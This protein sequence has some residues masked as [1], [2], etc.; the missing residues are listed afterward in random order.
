MP[1]ASDD[2]MVVGGKQTALDMDLSSLNVV[3]APEN[4]ITYQGDEIGVG[5][6][7]HTRL[8]EC[9]ATRVMNEIQRSL[10]WLEAIA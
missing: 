3:P 2:D 5:R 10:I 9:I 1:G 7:R 4:V 8:A 6:K